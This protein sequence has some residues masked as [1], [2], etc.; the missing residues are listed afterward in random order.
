MLVLK[1]YLLTVA[2]AVVAYV[3]AEFLTSHGM[4]LFGFRGWL[5]RKF[6]AKGGEDY[7][8]FKILVGCAYCV[9]GQWALWAYL[10]LVFTKPDLFYINEYSVWA[11]IA[12][13]SFTIFNVL[14]IKKAG[15]YGENGD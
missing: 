13:V 12:V 15:I 2:I 9:A 3:Y 8:L 10:Y 7:W 1:L 14:L 4:L 11:H 6:K 5:Y